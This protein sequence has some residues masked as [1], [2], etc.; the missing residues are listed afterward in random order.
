M[1]QVAAGHACQVDAQLHGQWLVQPVARAQFGHERG[2]H[3]AAGAGNGLHGIAGRRMHQHEVQ[4]HHGQHQRQAL[5]QPLEECAKKSH[6]LHLPGY[7]R[8]ISS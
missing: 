8:K 2:V 1:A 7:F 4:H 5:Q 6:G 3:A